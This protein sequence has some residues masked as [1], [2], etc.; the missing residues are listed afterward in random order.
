[1]L[2]EKGS[3]AMMWRESKPALA[4]V[5]GLLLGLGACSPG[6]GSAVCEEMEMRCLAKR[7]VELC[8]GGAWVQLEDCSESG[9][10][11]GM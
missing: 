11:C 7:F 9:R 2:G 8:Q 1:M 10:S 5:L 4:A 3:G 6:S